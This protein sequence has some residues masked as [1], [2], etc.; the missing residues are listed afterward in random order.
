MSENQ[1]VL[2]SEKLLVVLLTT[3]QFVHILDFVV[4][5][6]LGPTLME[7]YNISPIQFATLVSSYNISAGICGFFFALIADRF[8]RKKLLITSVFLFTLGTLFCGLS[9]DF[10][11]LLMARILTGCIGGI[12]NSIVYAIVADLIPFQRRGKAMGAIMSAFSLA[13]VLGVPI[14]LAISDYINFHFT[15][16]FI[17]CIALIVVILAINF[18]PNINNVVI[19]NSILNSLKSYKRIIFNKYYLYSYFLIFLMAFSTFILI[20]FLSPYAVKNM[21]IPTTSLKY[22]YLIGGACTVF[23][24]RFIG[25]L[26]DHFGGFKVY[27]I[28][29]FL[30][31]FPIIAYT[32]SGPLNVYLFLTLGSIFM[33]I[34][35]GRMIPS[36]TLISSIPKDVDRGSFM[37]FTNSLRSLGSALSTFF[38]GFIISEQATGQL[39][40]FDT[41]GYISIL[42]SFLT[43]FLAKEISKQVYANT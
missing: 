40:G 12:L 4:L 15:F 24:A 11:S 34:V 23:T 31:L 22:M 32:Q 8:E 1:S 28:I 29:I 18:I 43:I 41:A 30:S 39:T 16:Y 17:A 20:P 38:A 33:M 36:M 3:I 5:M 19:K 14:G 37:A 2:F 25:R 35:S 26:S 7:Y 21:L 42:F 9:N 10:G 13:S 27:K 6:P